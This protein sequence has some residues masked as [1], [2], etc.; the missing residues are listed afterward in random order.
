MPI[1]QF[2]LDRIKTTSLNGERLA[3]VF[4]KLALAL[5]LATDYTGGN[6]SNANLNVEYVA[7][8]D[9]LMPGDL[10]PIL[11]LTLVRQPAIPDANLLD[12]EII[13]AEFTV[14][15]DKEPYPEE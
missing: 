9:A 8:G 3:A 10:V 15:S 11:T 7:P 1:P 14:Q 6:A 2:L 12:A 5:A 13:D 4:A